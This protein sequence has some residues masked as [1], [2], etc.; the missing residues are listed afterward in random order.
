LLEDLGCKYQ[1]DIASGAGFEYYTG[2]IFQLFIGK[3]KIGGG[4][5]Y[6]AL[7]P[8]MGGDNIPASGFAL[9]L[10]RLVNLVKPEVL[11]EFPAQRVLVRGEGED[12]LKEAFGVA[13]RL[14]EAGH[15]AE[16]ALGGQ[17]ATDL[18]WVL[19]VRSEKPPFVLWDKAKA[20]KIEARSITE[21][22]AVLEEK[23]ADKDSLA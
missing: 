13:S 8:T 4:G 10:D 12:L 22:L 9:Y 15:I 6:D 7:I 2:M 19:E 3:E 11:T 5:R 18:R 21:V 16:I 14:R 20:N 23:S 1:I 17:E